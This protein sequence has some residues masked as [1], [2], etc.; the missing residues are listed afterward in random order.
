MSRSVLHNCLCPFPSAPRYG[1][2][3]TEIDDLSVR[4]EL[5]P[6]QS[7]QRFYAVYPKRSLVQHASAFTQANDLA[8]NPQ[9]LFRCQGAEES[10][11]GCVVTVKRN[12]HS[13]SPWLEA[14]GFLARQGKNLLRTTAGSPPQRNAVERV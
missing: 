8:W 5:R 2:G 11:A 9:T 12:G 10:I 14:L 4:R 1:S 3:T 7:W 6:C 13:S